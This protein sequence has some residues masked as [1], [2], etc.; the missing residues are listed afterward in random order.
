MTT[1]TQRRSRKGAGDEWRQFP[2]WLIAIIGFLVFY[3]FFAVF[4]RSH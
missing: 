3:G 1:N 4:T 2:W